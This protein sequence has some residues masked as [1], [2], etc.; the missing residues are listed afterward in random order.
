[1]SLSIEVARIKKADKT[2]RRVLSVLSV[3]LWHVPPRF[4]SLDGIK[5]DFSYSFVSCSRPAIHEAH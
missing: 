2:D 3:R 4:R 1:M 5:T